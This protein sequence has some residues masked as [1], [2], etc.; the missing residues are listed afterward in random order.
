MCWCGLL[1]TSA[2]TLAQVPEQRALDAVRGEIEA[3]KA[4]LEQENVSLEREYAALER[5]ERASAAA[6][7][8]LWEVRERVAANQSR[9]ESLAAE[10]AESERRLAG[11]RGALA[12]Q[13]R[14]S[15]L[16]GRQETIKLLLNQ[17]DPAQLGRMM[18]YYDYLNRA[19]AERIDAVANELD[20]LAEILAES[21]RVAEALAALER[22]RQ[23]E[24][25]KLATLRAER[26][27]AVEDLNSSI[28]SDE[29]AIARLANEESRLSKLVQDLNAVL[30][31][32]AVDSQAPFSAIRGTLPW[33]VGGALLNR[34]GDARGGPEVRW[35][36]VQIGAPAGTAVR[37]IYH[38]QI[39]YAD[40]FPGLGLLTI[41]DHG[42]GY[43]SLY[44][45]NEALF[46]ETGE[47]VTAGEAIGQV[48]D[49]GGQAQ[50]AL[51]FEILEDG[52]PVN[53]RT[54]LERA[55]PSPQ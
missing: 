35:R 2:V 51:Y 44:G 20:A 13:V 29:A 5:A 32:F 38:G 26:A 9:G 24:A 16:A 54:W 45:Y 46:K 40:W 47:W 4:R 52:E 11:E 30:S 28:D 3:L 6:R 31:E 10:R 34:Y 42:E 18:T 7:A 22:E 12:A 39:V 33:P 53:P 21:A 15:Y 49:S 17:Q 23:V 50:T 37:A 43:M 48:G 27:K 8:A 41:V 1:A 25:E 55:E 14:M 19:R 36:G